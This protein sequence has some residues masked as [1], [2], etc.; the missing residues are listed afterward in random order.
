[1][2]GT[3]NGDENA[4]NDEKPV[5]QVT[6][7][8]YYI[9]ET[10]VTQALWQAVMGNNPSYFK[11][12]PNLPVECVSWID[13]K[14]FIRKLN[15]LT[16]KNFRFLTEAEWEFA[17]R[18]GNKT[19]GF[20]YAGSRDILDF[21]I[22]WLGPNSGQRTHSVGELDPNELGLYDMSGNVWEWCQD[23]YGVYSKDSQL[24]PNGPSSGWRRV[25]RGG[26]WDN[27][28][29]HCRVSARNYSL[30]SITHNYLGLRLAL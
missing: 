28:A 8:D 30:P 20:I 21:D 24:N 3:N 6:L 18:G 26:G 19:K 16:G 23:W 22:A 9:G 14:A 29:G 11:G 17:A 2:M 5:H 7:S 27:D 25:R 4:D 13:C 12:N 15:R 1:M 10:Q